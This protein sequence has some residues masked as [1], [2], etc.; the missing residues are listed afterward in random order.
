VSETNVS[1]HSSAANCP[2]IFV[3]YALQQRELS[4][5]EF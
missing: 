2:M 3:S 5:G 1:W 4:N